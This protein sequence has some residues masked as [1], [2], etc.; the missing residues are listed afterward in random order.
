MS[1]LH[2]KQILDASITAA[3][4]AAGILSAYLRAD[5]T[6]AWAANQDAGGA[7][8]TNLGP[9]A[10]EN[11]AARLQDIH[12]IS[13]K[14]K[15]VA[16]TTG[17]ITLSGTQTIDG[18]AVVAGNRVLVRAQTAGA[19]NGIYVVAAGAWARAWDADS[20]AELRSA[21]VLVEQGTVNADKRFAQTADSITLNTT[22]L[23]FADIGSGAP[24]AFDTAS[25]KNMA[26]SLTSSDNQIGCA[27]AMAAT[28]AGDAYVR[29]FVNG[30]AQ[31]V[32]DG[33]KNR[34][35]YFSA[36]SGATAKTIANIAS[37][38]VMYWVGSVAGFQLAVTDVVDFAYA[39]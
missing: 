24:A 1:L 36:D 25:N 27:T 32:G 14:D 3:K 16:A 31:S 29:V 28:P 2:G 22:P 30:L 12:S 4:M 33:A 7:R 37:G 21:T 13:W 35:C 38:D 17:N 10:A 34:S 11:D 39:V 6:V 20:A 5:G 8:L 26:A 18:V 19:E 23:V 15:V 9:P